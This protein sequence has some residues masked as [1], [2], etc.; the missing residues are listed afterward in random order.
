MH[1]DGLIFR[2]ADPA[3]VPRCAAV[4]ALAGRGAPALVADHCAGVLVPVP[5]GRVFRSDA[6]VDARRRGGLGWSIVGAVAGGLLCNWLL[7]QAPA[8]WGVTTGRPFTIVSTSTFGTDAAPW[9]SGLLLRLVQVVWFAVG[10]FYAT[11]LTFQG[12]VTCGLI[13]PRFLPSFGPGELG[14]HNSLFL[15]TTLVWCG[16]IAHAGYYLTARHRSP[17]E[18]LYLPFGS[19]ADRDGVVAAT[20]GTAVTLAE[21]G[22][23][24]W[25]LASDRDDPAHLRILRDGGDGRGGLGSRLPRCAGRSLGGLVRSRAARG[26]SARRWGW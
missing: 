19:D 11:V 12:L 1:A 23:G 24:K 15:F 18:G 25:S 4:R 16:L 21:W 3:I 8:L 17:D 10:V 20:L 7:F 9:I 14:W 22:L 6:E 5:L 13:A 26:A 2:R